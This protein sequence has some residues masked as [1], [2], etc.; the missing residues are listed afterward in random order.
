VAAR[1]L[2]EIE[3]V[4]KDET[5]GLRE[6]VVRS[7]GDFTV[8]LLAITGPT[9]DERLLLAGTGTL[10]QLAGKQFILTARHVWECR[11]KSAD[12]I[13]ITLKPSLKDHRFTIDRREVVPFGLPA[14]GEWNEWGPDLALLLVP[15]NCVGGIAAIKSFWNLAGR[16]GGEIEVLEAPVLMGTPAAVGTITERH[17]ALEIR[18]MFLGSESQQI[19]GGLDYLQYDFDLSSQGLRTFGGVSGGGVWNV[20]L[21]RSP[22]ND[23]IDWKMILHGVAFFELP[24][25]DDHRII[26]CHGPQSI[27]LAIRD[28]GES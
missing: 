1:D 19:R 10:V 20:Y 26:R 13:G 25:V 28:L 22:S 5:S 14:P 16:T 2:R 27:R 11:L 6:R 18:G 7:I 8:A 23:E 17:A 12:R 4:F 24:I 3:K 21:H 15:A 9:N